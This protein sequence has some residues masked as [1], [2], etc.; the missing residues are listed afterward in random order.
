MSVVWPEV[1]GANARCMGGAEAGPDG[2]IYDMALEKGIVRLWVRAGGPDA[3]RELGL[4]I[5]YQFFK[6]QLVFNGADGSRMAF[7]F[8][9]KNRE[10][11]LSNPRGGECGDWAIFTTKP[12]IRQ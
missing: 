1:K 8:T 7:D 4:E 5:P 6:D 11:T 9:Y 12:W 2:A 3:D 10:L